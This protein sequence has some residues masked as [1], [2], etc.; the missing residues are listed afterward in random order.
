MDAASLSN[1][2]ISSEI[3]AHTYTAPRDFLMAAR[4]I[5][6]GLNGA[7]A[8]R[9]IQVFLGGVR[10]PRNQQT[11]Y[12]TDGM[13]LYV[14]NLA[15]KS[16]EQV[17]IKVSGS[18]GDTSA[19]ISSEIFAVDALNALDVARPAS[20]VAGSPLDD[21]HRARARLANKVTET[22]DTRALSVKDDDGVT[23]LFSLTP[24]EADGV[25]TL[26]PQ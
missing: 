1:Q 11:N 17:A 19:Y 13:V 16:G 5:L 3:T 26:A 18:V 9:K 2:D 10:G 15:V 24:T 4:V 25:I 7:S 20:P 12:G 21:V 14:S 23:E 6:T 22:I 8:T